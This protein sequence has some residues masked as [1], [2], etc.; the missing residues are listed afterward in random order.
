MAL[1]KRPIDPDKL[2]A[3]HEKQQTKIR[4][5]LNYTEF[6]DKVKLDNTKER[7]QAMREGKSFLEEQ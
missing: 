7:N 4:E 3:F 1:M 2:Q 6:T 5:M